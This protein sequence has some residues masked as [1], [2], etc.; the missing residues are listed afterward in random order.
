MGE[1][2]AGC[3]QGGI[4]DTA[5]VAVDGQA[6]GVKPPPGPM[7][8]PW[9]ETWTLQACSKRALVTMHFTPSASGTEIQ[10]TLATDSTPTP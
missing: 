6:P 2:P 4:I 1:M 3:E 8:K 5:F 9:T 7:L 10:A